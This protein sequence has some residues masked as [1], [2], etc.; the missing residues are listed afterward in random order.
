[1]ANLTMVHNLVGFPSVDGVYW[2]L[3]VELCF[4]AMVFALMLRGGTRSIEPLLLCLVGLA[5]ADG[6]LFAD[7][8]SGWV[9]RLRVVQAHSWPNRRCA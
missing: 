7:V 4:Y 8:K 9:M 3:Q 6:L 5:T 1:M 2:T